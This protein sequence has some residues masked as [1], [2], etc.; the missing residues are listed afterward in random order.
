MQIELEPSEPNLSTLIF[1]VYKVLLQSELGP[2]GPNL[3]HSKIGP[4]DWPVERLL[5]C[6]VPAL[7]IFSFSRMGFT[8]YLLVDCN[9]SGWK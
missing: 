2:L 7:V 4:T 5:A 3:E 6:Q 8:P 9:E 1:H